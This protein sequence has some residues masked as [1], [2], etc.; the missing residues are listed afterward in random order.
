MVENTIIILSSILGIVLI[1]I[2]GIVVN[3]FL[4]VWIGEKIGGKEKECSSSGNSRHDIPSAAELG[5]N[6]RMVR[7][8]LKHGWRDKV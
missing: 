4:V 2:L 8:S 5:A 3:A 1:L 6:K 7:R